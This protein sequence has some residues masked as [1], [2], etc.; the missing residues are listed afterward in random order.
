MNDGSTGLCCALRGGKLTIANVGDCRVVLVGSRRV[1][2]LSNDHKPNNRVEYSRILS[3]GGNVINCIGVPRVN[4]ILAVS[5]AFGNRTLRDVIRPDPELS[6]REL[7]AD[8]HYIVIASDGVWD[9][10]KNADI[11]RACWQHAGRP[12]QQ[13]AN[14]IIQMALALG[15]QDN[16]T[17]IVIGVAAY[18]AELKYLRQQNSKLQL[19]FQKENAN[20]RFTP[21]PTAA[22]DG[23]GS[24]DIV[25]IF[26]PLLSEHN[27]MRNT[28]TAGRRMRATGNAS[29][30]LEIAGFK[31]QI[32]NAAG[33]S[34]C[35]SAAPVVS[36]KKAPPLRLPDCR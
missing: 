3:L 19:A 32:N 12:S 4:G 18:I 9:V 10:V 36:R 22:S 26:K 6:E 28:R 20:I 17:C 2:Q 16:V 1:E 23:S 27:L 7:N 8:D 29:V 33:G 5:R 35:H 11:Y 30:E 13:I 31:N 25:P 14:D 15:S 21:S 34:R 24:S